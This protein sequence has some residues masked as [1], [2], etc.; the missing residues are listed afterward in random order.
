MMEY[1]LPRLQNKPYYFVTLVAEETI[2]SEEP[3]WF[4]RNPDTLIRAR[5]VFEGLDYPVSVLPLSN[6]PRHERQGFVVAD[7]GGTLIGQACR[8][9]SVK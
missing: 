5:L 3:L 4:S 9:I 1:W 8:D 6:L 7:W 2:N